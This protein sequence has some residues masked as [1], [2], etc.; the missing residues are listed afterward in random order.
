MPGTPRHTPPSPAEHKDLL[1]RDAF[2]PL[3]KITDIRRVAEIGRAAGDHDDR[4]QHIRDAVQPAAARAR[5]WKSSSTVRTKYLGG[6][7]DLTAGLLVG[8]AKMT[9]HVRKI[10]T[11]LYGGTISPQVAWLVIRGIKTLALRMERHNSTHLR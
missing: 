2:N 3:V 1:D 6:H 10:A 4:G 8:T 11:K 7:S 5:R 9:K